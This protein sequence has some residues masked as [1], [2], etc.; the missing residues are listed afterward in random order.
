MKLVFATHNVHKF[1]EINA[2]I[3]DS[4]S[5]LSLKDINCFEDIEETGKTLLENASIKAQY[6]YDKYKLNCFADDTGLEIKAL[7][8]EPGVF[9]ARYAGTNVTYDDNVNKVLKEL[10]NVQDR[11]AQFRTVIALIIDGKLQ[12]FEGTVNGEITLDKR[13]NS[14][15]GYDPIFLPDDYNQTFAQMPLEQKNRISHRAKALNKLI[16]YLNKYVNI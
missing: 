11:S 2:L 15:F 13:G 10:S 14:G 8:G 12:T 3:P 1:K 16:S 5:L 6:V 7:N 4:I 9:S